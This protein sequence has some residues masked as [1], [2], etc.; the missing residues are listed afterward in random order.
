MGEAGAALILIVLPKPNSLGVVT[1]ASII[2]AIPSLFF[3][4]TRSVPNLGRVDFHHAKIETGMSQRYSPFIRDLCSF[5]LTSRIK[6][7]PGVPCTHNEC[8]RV[9]SRVD[10]M[11]DHVRRIHRKAS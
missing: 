2:G 4:A 11:K 5:S 6:H 9:F 8:E 10:N 3:A 7:K 1:C